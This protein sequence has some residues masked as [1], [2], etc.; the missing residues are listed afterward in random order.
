MFFLPDTA[1]RNGT[2]FAVQVLRLNEYSFKWMLF[3]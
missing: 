1:E 3:L 2:F